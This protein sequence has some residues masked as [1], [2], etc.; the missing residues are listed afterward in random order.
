MTKTLIRFIFLALTFGST[1]F[2]SAQVGN[3]TGDLGVPCSTVTG[4]MIGATDACTATPTTYKVRIFEMGLCTTHPF[5]A[6]KTGT[7][8]NRDSCVTTYVDAAPATVDI[9]ALIGG[10][11]Q[12]LAGTSNPPAEGTYPHAFLVMD[13]TFITSASFT[14]GAG[15]V[16][17]S[18]TNGNAGDGIG[19]IQERTDNLVQFGT[20]GGGGTDCD[21]GFL[22]AQV[23]GGTIDAFITN[24]SLVRSQRTNGATAG[25]C[26]N[27]G[28]LIGVMNLAAPVVVT[29]ETIQ[30]L[31]NFDLTNQGS[32]FFDTG[33]VNNDPDEYGS[34]PFSGAFTIISNQ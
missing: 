21:S 15:T 1:Q 4:Q 26:D 16:H 18:L 19:N 31:F 28:R 29:S 10:T 25:A 8:F 33:G 22:A 24:D 30:V 5:T 9:A 14:D 13:D 27:A 34:G 11:P 32:Q 3:V 7:T 2:A 20:G 17:V 23:T 6:A 12:P